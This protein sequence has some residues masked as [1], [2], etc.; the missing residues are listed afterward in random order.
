VSNFHTLATG[1]DV[2]TGLAVN[3]SGDVFVSNALAGTILRVTT[4]GATTVFARNLSVPFGLAFN[5]AGDLFVAENIG[6]ISRITPGGQM[7]PR[8]K[9]W[10]IQP[11]RHQEMLFGLPSQFR[12]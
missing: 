5:Q 6:R 9:H 2:P 1:L 10:N 12:I 7:T 3:S 8:L 11:R 4:Q